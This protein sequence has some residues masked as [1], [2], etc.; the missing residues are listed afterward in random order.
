MS[1]T[2]QHILDRA[3]E[4]F[5]AHGLEGV[6]M[7]R[8]AQAVGVTAPALYRHFESKE[9]VLHEVVA[10]AVRSLGAYLYRALAGKSPRERLQ[11]ALDGYA[12]FGL[13]QQRLFE[14][15]FGPPEWLGLT[16]IPADIEAQG[17]A[18]GCFWNDRIRECI[19]AGILRE[20]DPHEVGLTIWSHAQGLVS[21]FHRGRISPDGKVLDRAAF[22]ALYRRSVERM[23]SGLAEVGDPQD[24]FSFS[25]TSDSSYGF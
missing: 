16:E 18:I 11:L 8:L 25:D 1:N 12:E 22:L 19:E 5:L 9:Q 4:L 2:R 3:C 17:A 10:E 6:S 13:D 20:G 23:M 24:S 7:R 21:L 15:V 14:I